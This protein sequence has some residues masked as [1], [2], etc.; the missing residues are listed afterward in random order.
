MLL[1]STADNGHSAA[2]PTPVDESFKEYTPKS[3]QNY[4]Q[5]HSFQASI[6]Y[7]KFIVLNAFCPSAY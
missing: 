4:N 5:T 7:F 2:T 3:T 6:S 1:P